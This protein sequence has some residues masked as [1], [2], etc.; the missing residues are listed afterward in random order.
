MERREYTPTKLAQTY[1]TTAQRHTPPPRPSGELGM[2][3]EIESLRAQARQLEAQNRQMSV[4]V[5]TLRRDKE[6]N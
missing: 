6:L 4:E 1:H 5:E 3:R 2:V